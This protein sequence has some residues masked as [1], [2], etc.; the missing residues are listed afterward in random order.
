MSLD[1]TA[2]STAGTGSPG[3]T[4]IMLFFLAFFFVFL[5][6]PQ[7]V[8][9]KSSSSIFSS[10]GSRTGGRAGG[11][12]GGGGGVGAGSSTLLP[13]FPGLVFLPVAALNQSNSS[14]GVT[15][16]TAGTAST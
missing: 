9:L 12:G 16:S 10:T 2:F 11:G 7:T 13:F 3:T 5:V 8:K 1:V 15:T 14:L 4:S 6:A